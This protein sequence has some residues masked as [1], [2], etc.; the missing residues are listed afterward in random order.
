MFDK[1]A[2]ADLA[3]TLDPTDIDPEP[4]TYG[5]IIP[6]TSPLA[7]T[8]MDSKISRDTKPTSEDQM[9]LTPSQKLVEDMG[10]IGGQWVEEFDYVVK[11]NDPISGYLGR[12][13]PDTSQE[14]NYDWD[15]VL[16]TLG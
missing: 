15:L 7:A 14:M 11:S 1:E 9:D 8:E 13:H 16:E 2:L 12:I 10:Y 5:G 6:A 4:A 3:A